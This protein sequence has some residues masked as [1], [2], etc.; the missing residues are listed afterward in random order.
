M[1]LPH[2]L[3]MCSLGWDLFLSAILTYLFFSLHRRENPTDLVGC[4][5]LRC[6]LLALMEFIL[7]IPEL[8]DLEGVKHDAVSL[9][10]RASQMSGMFP[11]VYPINKTLNLCPQPDFVVFCAEVVSQPSLQEHCAH[12]YQ[13]MR[14][15]CPPYN[16]A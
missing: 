6:L 8:C 13:L 5:A 14:T 15:I 9:C 2:L 16:L 7:R 10:H 12:S 4:L 11:E 3:R 1:V